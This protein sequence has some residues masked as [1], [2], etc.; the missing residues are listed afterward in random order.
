MRKG[1]K[2]AKMTIVTRI[3]KQGKERITGGTCLSPKPALAR[4]TIHNLPN[5]PKAPTSG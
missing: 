4:A 1:K 5:V 3:S 2:S